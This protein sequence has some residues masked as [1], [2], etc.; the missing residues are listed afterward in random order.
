MRNDPDSQLR[1][2]YDEVA[3]QLTEVNDRDLWGPMMKE[4]LRDN[5]GPDSCLE[6]LEAERQ[7]LA[8]RIQQSLERLNRPVD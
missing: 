7:R 2:A 3:G 1:S 5:G 8:L 4:L 6:Y